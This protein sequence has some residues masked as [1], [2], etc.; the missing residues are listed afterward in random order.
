MNDKP[1]T[2][3]GWIKFW[4]PKDDWY[5]LDAESRKTY[6]DGLKGIE[7]RAAAQGG[8]LV[9]TYKC[10]GQSPWARFE[11]WEFSSL[12][13]VIDMTNDLE[14]IGHYQYFSENNTVGRQYERTGDPNSWV[15]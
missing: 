14:K 4:T 11:L 13:S 8:R 3:I 6:F 12:Q 10:R 15:I 5:G 9:G 1:R 7:D 2:P